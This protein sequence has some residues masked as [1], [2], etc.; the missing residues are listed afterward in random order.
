MA[1]NIEKKILIREFNEDR[2]IEVVGKLE[3]N[4]EIGSNK[5]GVSI[6]T[7]MIGDHDP[8][9]RIR[10]Y[11]LHVMLVAELLENGELVGVVRGCIRDVGT[12]FREAQLKM[13]CILGL[14][15]LPQDIK[16]EKLHIDHA[17]SLYKKRLSSDKEIY[18][19]DIEAILKGKL[20]LGTW[21][22]CFKKEGWVDFHSK[23]KNEDITKIS[24]SW[25]MFSIWNTCEAYK[26]QIRKSHPLRSFHATLSQAREKISLCLKRPNSDDDDTFPKS[27]GFL[28]LY[29]L[30]GEGEKV[31]ELMKSVWSF[32]SK[33]CQNVKDCKVIVT[34][35]GVTDP[36]IKHVPQESSMS[37]INDLWYT[38]KMMFHDDDDMMGLMLAKGSL[39]NVFV[40]PR[41]F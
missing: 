30:I 13:G 20:S 19:A 29:G 14:R 33:L 38:K 24:S 1:D 10:F 3:R 22:C 21:V 5:K 23:E 39:G 27:I 40:D 4:C 32:A 11:S 17:I 12:G 26:L 41:D 18:P 36:L 25:M 31:G 37:C 34:E 28:F 35:L 7:Y 6:F 9:C 15:N 16:I 2:D 8:L